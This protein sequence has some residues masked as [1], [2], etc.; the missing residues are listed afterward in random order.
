M[1]KAYSS[2]RI[3]EGE[4]GLN[5]CGLQ[6]LSDHDYR[7]KRKRIDFSLMYLA[8]GK[9]TMFVDRK[10]I[11]VNEGEA[12][13][14]PPDTEQRFLVLRTDNSINKWVHFGGKL[15]EPLIAGGPRK[16]VISSRREF[17]H[18]LDELIRTYNGIGEMRELKKTGYLTIIIALLRESE[19][20]AA[21]A[22]SRVSHRMTDALNYIHINAYSEVDLD[23][24]AS[25]CYMSRDRFNH[26]FKDVTGFSPSVYVTKIR[27]ERAKQ[28]LRD[29]GMSV[30]ECAESVGFADANYFCRVFRKETGLSPKRY[31]EEGDLS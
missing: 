12:L 7:I 9:A 25:I 22:Q 11:E 3:V 2:E 6:M 28:L 13:F 19:G 31:A 17:E 10:K 23:Y 4:L 5:S 24:A 21:K 16:I 27:I 20:H 14:Y 18:A 26:V 15:A 30:R 29:L 1:G 8:K